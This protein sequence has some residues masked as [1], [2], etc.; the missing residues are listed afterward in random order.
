MHPD[1]DHTNEWSAYA[2]KIRQEVRRERF[3]IACIYIGTIIGV[4]L[5]CH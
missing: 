5:W 4:I 1:R 2:R 3:A